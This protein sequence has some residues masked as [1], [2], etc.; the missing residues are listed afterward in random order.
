MLVR[1]A[2]GNVNQTS[3]ACDQGR[4]A[5]MTFFIHAR[6]VAG[7]I[8]LRRDTH[9]S[10]IQKAKELAE[11]RCF[12]VEICRGSEDCPLCRA[13]LKGLIVSASSFRF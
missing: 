12:E 11:A 7:C 3:R 1:D 10:A 4:E 5:Q 9:E 8:T 2:Q 6:D 13:N